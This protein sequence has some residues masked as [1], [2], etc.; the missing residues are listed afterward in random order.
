MSGL[1]EIPLLL[2]GRPAIGHLERIEPEM[3]AERPGSRTGVAGLPVGEGFH[4]V[5]GQ[6][7]GPDVLTYRVPTSD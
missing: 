5:P 3:L 7:S 6:R 4:D 1:P 2:D